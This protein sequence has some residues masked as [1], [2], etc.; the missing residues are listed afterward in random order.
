MTVT[1]ALIH[2]IATHPARRSKTLVRL[3]SGGCVMGI[4]LTLGSLHSELD[5]QGFAGNGVVVDGDV[6]INGGADTIIVNASVAQIDWTP[7]DTSAPGTIDFLPAGNSVDFQAGTVTE[8]TVLNRIIPT[9]GSVPLLN[10]IIELNG[11]ITSNPGGKV[12]FYTPGGFL[13]GGTAVIDVGGLVLTTSLIDDEAS[14]FTGTSGTLSLTGT[15]TDT[16]AITIAAGASI[17]TSPDDSYLALVA[18]RIVQGGTVSVNGT[19]AYVAAEEA[20]ISI[21][22]GLFDITVSTGSGDTNGVV[23]TGTTTGPGS[24]SDP[25]AGTP[26]VD[27]QNIFMVAVPK[28]QAITMLL[29]GSIGFAAATG[30][31]DDGGVTLAAGYDILESDIGTGTGGGGNANMT[32]D[33]GNFSS[34]VNAH[35]ANTLAIAPA[36]ALQFGMDTTFSSDTSI[37]VDVADSSSITANASLTLR[38]SGTNGGSID[39]DTSGLSTTAGTITVAD[40]FLLDATGNGDFGISSPSTVG[41]DAFGG[42]INIT[43]VDDSVISGNI[44]RADAT[45]QGGT[46]FDFSGNAQGGDININIADNAAINFTTSTADVSASARL[47]SPPAIG[48]GNAD[49][50]DLSLSASGGTLGM[51]DLTLSAN[52]A[53]GE[54]GTG[55]GGDATGGL[56]DINITGGTHSMTSLIAEA[57]T[58][59]GPTD[60]GTYGSAIGASFGSTGSAD[61]RLRVSG[62]STIFETTG[63]LGVSAIA[64]ATTGGTGGGIIQGGNITILAEQGGTLR[65]AG[66]FFVSADAFSQS[67]SGGDPTNSSLTQGGTIGFMASGGTIEALDS[68]S[69][70]TDALAGDASA[71]SGDAQAGNITLS[72]TND[73]TQRGSVS[74]GACGSFCTESYFTADAEGG[75]SSIGGDGLGGSIDIF[76]EDA[77]ITGLGETYVSASGFAGYSLTDG[78]S[79]GDGTGGAILMEIQDGLTGDGTMTFNDF[80]GS[81]LGTAT[82]EVEGVEY[83]LGN[84]GIGTGGSFD[85]AV[86]TGVLTADRLDIASDGIGGASE[87]QDGTIGSGDAF[88]AGNGA[89]G[90]TN[91]NLSGGTI[92]VTDMF[93]TADGYGGFSQSASSTDIIASIAGNGT[94][95]TVDFSADGGT[96]NVTNLTVSA[97][98]FGGIALRGFESAGSDSGDGIGGSAD[99]R[100]TSDAVINATDIIVSA[101]GTG[102]MGGGAMEFFSSVPAFTLNAGNGGDGTGG[103][104]A[105]ALEGGTLTAG[106]FTL[107]A[108]GIGGEGGETDSLGTGGAGGTGIGGDALFTFLSEGHDITTTVVKSQGSGGSGGQARYFT[109]TDNNGDPIYEVGSGTGGVGGTGSGGSAEFLVFEDPTLPNV[110]VDASNIGGAGG[111]GAVG[112]AGGNGLG[113]STAEL[114]VFNSFLEVTNTTLV[115]AEGVGGAG[116]D[117]YDGI[118]GNGGGGQGGD[119]SINVTGGSELITNTTNVTASGNG[120]HAG[121]SGIRSGEGIDGANGG[122][123]AGGNASILVEE[124]GIYTIDGQA[125]VFADS[126]GGNG[127][128]GIA[129]ITVAG[130]PGGDGG[131][132]IAGQAEVTIDTAAFAAFDLDGLEIS[133]TAHGGDGGSGGAGGISAPATNGGNAGNGGNATGGDA[134]FMATDAD[135][136]IETLV[137]RGNATGGEGGTGG[138]GAANGTSGIGGSGSGNAASFSNIASGSPSSGELRYVGELTIEASG[139]NPL[140][141]AP[142]PVSGRASF[143]NDSPTAGAVDLS[144]ALLT[145]T[146]SGDPNISGQSGVFIDLTTGRVNV[147]EGLLYTDAA[148]GITV[149]GPGALD[150]VNDLR[151][152]GINGVTISHINRPAGN[153]PDT[154]TGNMISLYAFGPI[155]ATDQSTI[156]TAGDFF[157]YSLFSTVSL[158]DI[159]AGGSIGIAG[160][161]LALLELDA[162]EDIA[163]QSDNSIDLDTA[164]A[165]D[166]LEITSVSGDI[167]IGSGS[168]GASGPDGNSVNFTYGNMSTS[169]GSDFG[170]GTITL[171]GASGVFAANLFSAGDTNLFSGGDIIVD[172]SLDAFG[173]VTADGA[174]IAIDSDGDISFASANAFA[175][176]FLLEAFGTATF[177]GDATA[178]NI[179]LSSG[180]IVIEA[181][182][183]IIADASLSLIN[184]D[185]S[186]PSY[187]GG[188]D[189]TAGYSLSADEITR[190]FSTNTTVIADEVSVINSTSLGNSAPDVFIDDMLI[191]AGTGGTIGANGRFD[192]ITPGKARVIGAVQVTGAG[193]DGGFSIIADDALEIIANSGSIDVR[194]GN[195]NLGGFIFLFSEDIIAATSGMIQQV[196]GASSTSERDSL[197]STPS[198]IASDTGYLRAGRL[199][200]GAVDGLYIQNSGTGTDYDDRRGFTAN[201]VNIFTES[202]ATEI[203]INGR[204]AIAGTGGGFITGIEAIPEISINGQF[205][206]TSGFALDSTINGCLIIDPASCAGITPPPP[207]QN[208]EFEDLPTREEDIGAEL[209]PTTGPSGDSLPTV[210]IEI[211]EFEEVG[212]PPLIDEP[213]TGAGNDDLWTS[214]DCTDANSNNCGGGATQ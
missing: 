114:N 123:G 162:G 207:P 24:Q 67:G 163:L 149:D 108:S 214:N 170:A 152:E 199:D 27:R 191:T 182:A 131:N 8:Y 50:G 142:F 11:T 34:T 73:G 94:G 18:P 104:A 158:N 119:A 53:G 196:A 52:A 42:A 143:V 81:A 88:T 85:L 30:T 122:S 181:D 178:T 16:S 121:A 4:A 87:N 173:Q 37:D 183:N 154:L 161:T 132:A 102:A 126:V 31:Q 60:T 98:G 89:G 201:A 177:I 204:L 147:G 70:S 202:S 137:I 125:R 23:H 3:L 46:G 139:L 205:S 17:T 95:G 51:G 110:T 141:A 188:A 99:F 39:V 47:G 138:I 198:G 77:D 206:A 10:Q 151:A 5:A 26:I 12:W 6:N 75:T 1:P 209:N 134:S 43:A 86:S 33:A 41:N 133:A 140:S 14:D 9:D 65:A 80:Y 211:K 130:G 155:N 61:I 69:L 74:Y 212:F 106:T 210:I 112:G 83:N 15:P 56:I 193:V 93:I 76:V 29:G 68:L 96:L 213:I 194:D 150:F 124:D 129:G 35:T 28:N 97:S 189:T 146:A 63:F 185:T 13:V 111:D 54:A 32:I 64:D 105:V 116:G 49:G 135:Y 107:S 48:G 169:A 148:I 100:I 21:N 184:F 7:S 44:L 109:G 200:M 195:G 59:A 186:N 159:V 79:A 118:G 84:G 36:G 90:T 40:T 174:N 168:A 145:M 19:V 92:N 153:T 175:G 55:A 91:V 128:S 176:S 172:G 160:D 57:D 62:A 171:D 113:G 165:A 117:G 78:N 115:R 25:T 20:T 101:E 180:D 2:S 190:I 179:A 58:A 157:A 208:E 197:L 136:E 120:G 164:G 166:D 187:I 127:A 45:A 82:L 203:I 103:N 144:D 167:I 192:I 156:N 38:V 66:S 71:S 22:A 72:A